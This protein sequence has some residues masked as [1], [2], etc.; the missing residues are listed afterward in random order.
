MKGEQCLA[1]LIR[2][3]ENDGKVLEEEMNEVSDYIERNRKA[4]G[5]YISLNV[6]EA[7]KELDGICDKAV[8]V[9]YVHEDSH[10]LHSTK[11]L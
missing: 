5:L 4:G 11:N 8:S 10:S 2:Y 9:E 1:A 7:A 3:Y 6:D